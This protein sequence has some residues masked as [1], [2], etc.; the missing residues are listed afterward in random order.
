MMSR[1]ARGVEPAVLT[2]DGAVEETKK[3]RTASGRRY[4]Q[5]SLRDRIIDLNYTLLEERQLQSVILWTHELFL[6]AV[7][8]ACLSGPHLLDTWFQGLSEF[9]SSLLPDQGTLVETVTQ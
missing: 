4:V 9:T 6:L 8:L 7:L 3:R 2:R 1:Q 5:H